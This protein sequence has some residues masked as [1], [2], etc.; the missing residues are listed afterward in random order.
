MRSITKVKQA[1]TLQKNIART[2]QR[3]LRSGHVFQAINK[4]RDNNTIQF[5][6]FDTQ[7]L[8][9]DDIVL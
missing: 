7:I 4:A 6:M 9:T 2:F 5:A 1:D 8:K 3:N